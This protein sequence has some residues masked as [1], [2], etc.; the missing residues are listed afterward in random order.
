MTGIDKRLEHCEEK[1][2]KLEVE[3]HKLA[4][5]LEHNEDLAEQ[6]FEALST[7][8]LEIKDLLKARAAFE[9]ERAREAREYRLRR[10]ELEA[11]EQV[12]HKAWIRSLVNPQTIVIVAAIL[13]S[14]LGLQAAELGHL[15]AAPVV[16]TP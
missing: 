14:M 15:I 4:L 8:Q 1:L 6:R 13:A 2:Q 16:E 9:E 10:E 12:A 3:M 5:E 11:A 7:S